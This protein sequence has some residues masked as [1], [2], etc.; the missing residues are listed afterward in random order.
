MILNYK[1]SNIHYTTTGTGEAIVLLHGFLET[2]DMWYDF[3]PEL[4]KSHQVICVDLLGHGKTD[5]IGYVHTMEEMA[6]AVFEVLNY[7]NIKNAYFVG[8][9]MGGYVSLALAEKHPKLIKGLCLMNSSYNEDDE[10][11]IQIRNRACKMAKLN[12]KVLINMSFANLFTE[13]SK[14]KFEVEYNNA[15]E[16]ALKTPLQGYIAAQEGMKLRPN[17]F[18]IFKNLN[19]KKLIIIGKKDGL[20]NRKKIMNQ[21]EET[22]INYVEFSEGHMS[23]IENKPDLSYNLLHFVEK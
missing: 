19:A 16:L 4:S 5:C 1:N 23:S 10:E 7:L 13:E 9:S 12:Y 18:E 11:R 6:E 2:L 20:I 8:H 22:D 3:I 15:L 21:I 17:R 14:I